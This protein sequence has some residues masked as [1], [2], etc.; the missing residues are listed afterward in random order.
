MDYVNDVD[1]SYF[2]MGSERERGLRSILLL[3]AFTRLRGLRIN[4][5]TGTGTLWVCESVFF[6]PAPRGLCGEAGSLLQ[7]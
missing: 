7:L 2:T 5:V 6:G 1:M 4:A 3:L